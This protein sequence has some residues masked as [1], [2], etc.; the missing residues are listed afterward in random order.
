MT[1]TAE[2]KKWQAESDAHILAEANVIKTTPARVNAAK[3]AAKQM[4]AEEM[5]KA[6]A[7]KKVA[8][9]KPA[10]K[11]KPAPKRRPAARRKR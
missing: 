8:T 1:L 9:A 3:K 2:Q 6:A 10:A 7:M 5:K 11:R 4:A